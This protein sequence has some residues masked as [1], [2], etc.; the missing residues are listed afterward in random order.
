M[1]L[2]GT[3]LVLAS[4]SPL[5][6]IW[7]EEDIYFEYSFILMIALNIFLLAK[8]NLFNSILYTSGDYRSVAYISIIESSVRIFLTYI[9]V[10]LLGIYGLPQRNHFVSHSF[11]FTRKFDSRKTGHKNLN[12]FFTHFYIRIINLFYCCNTRV[13]S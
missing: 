12:F 9:L 7:L 10:S 3:S 5:L 4:I 11:I 13:L 2:F 6:F 8:L 1:H